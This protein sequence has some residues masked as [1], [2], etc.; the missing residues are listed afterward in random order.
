MSWGRRTKEILTR[1]WREKLLA[2]VLAFLFW[3]MIKAQI[4]NTSLFYGSDR[5]PKPER[6]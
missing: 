1:N 2:L 6:L 5:A 4:S 3:I